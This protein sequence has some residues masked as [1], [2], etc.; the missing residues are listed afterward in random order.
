MSK[1]TACVWC[2]VILKVPDTYNDLQNYAVCSTA[3]KAAEMTF[4]Q[5]MSDSEI[6]RRI[7]YGILTQGE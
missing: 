3:C 6:N 1:L 7:H 2:S 5:W 4:Q